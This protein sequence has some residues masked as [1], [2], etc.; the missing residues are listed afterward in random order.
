[1]C[2][3]SSYDLQKEDLK[4]KSE[5][6]K[7]EDFSVLQYDAVLTVNSYSNILECLLLPFT[8]SVHSPWA[9]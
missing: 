1:M 2:H 8:A 9:A 5:K 4:Y 6:T 7:A 3:G